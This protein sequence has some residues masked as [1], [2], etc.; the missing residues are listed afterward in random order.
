MQSL[1]GERLLSNTEA[2]PH[3]LLWQEMFAIF[4]YNKATV[5]ETLMQKTCHAVKLFG[6]GG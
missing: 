1:P 4:F 3:E 5:A 6:G 2:R